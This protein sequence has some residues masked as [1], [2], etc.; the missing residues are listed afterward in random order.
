MYYLFILSTN[1]VRKVKMKLLIVLFV[2][3]IVL[4]IISTFFNI[5]TFD[6][7]SLIDKNLMDARVTDYRIF[8]MYSTTMSQPRRFKDLPD[9]SVIKYSES[10]ELYLLKV[11]EKIYNKNLSFS[12]DDGDIIA[13]LATNDIHNQLYKTLENELNFQVI[14]YNDVPKDK[15]AFFLPFMRYLGIDFKILIPKKFINANV[16]QCFVIDS[17]A[18]SGNSRDDG[19][20]AFYQQFFPETKFI[21]TFKNDVTL[22]IDHPINA[23]MLVNKHDEYKIFKLN[24]PISLIKPGDTVFLTNQIDLTMN[25]KYQMRPDGLLE[26]MPAMLFNKFFVVSK[27][28]HIDILVGTSSNYKGPIGQVWFTDLDMHGII[29]KT[30]NGH[31][32]IVYR[33]GDSEKLYSCIDD[34]RLKTKALCES[35]YNEAG[36]LKEGGPNIWDKRCAKDTDCPFYKT[37]QSRGKCDNGYC[38]M[39]VGIIKAGFTKYFLNETSYPYCHGCKKQGPNCCQD[40]WQPDYAFSFDNN[41]QIEEPFIPDL[42]SD[43][44][45]KSPTFELND[46]DF[47][48]LFENMSFDIPQN[49]TISKPIDS[50]FLNVSCKELLSRANLTQYVYKFGKCDEYKS[51]GSRDFFNATVCVHAPSKSKGKVLQYDCQT[52]PYMFANI[53][54]IGSISEDQIILLSHDSS[55]ASY[56][57]SP[58]LFL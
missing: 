33:Q 46:A 13:C 31:T 9:N 15:V 43:P 18:I 20:N 22:T 21:E 51:D 32:T 25:G 30:V 34:S 11:L 17:I 36:E 53:K 26:T 52:N 14:D 19:A 55:S 37:G 38:E 12:K 45:S 6:T 41:K 50:F 35:K 44:I 5:E 49:A 47:Q 48:K 42:T 23:E 40:Q 54:V 10:S 3:V 39:P 27:S 2:L 8:F 1:T 28:N 57:E 24:K 29:T 56:I 4:G 16:I 58:S 7:I